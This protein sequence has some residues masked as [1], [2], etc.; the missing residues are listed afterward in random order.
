MKKLSD[1]S[2]QVINTLIEHFADV[3][4]EW[5]ECQCEDLLERLADYVIL[6]PELQQENDRLRELI[7]P[8]CNCPKCEPDGLEAL[9]EKEYK[10][11]EKDEN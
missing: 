11:E 5:Q 10:E 9:M 2:S 8:K 3:T 6:V 1:K 7:N 4:M